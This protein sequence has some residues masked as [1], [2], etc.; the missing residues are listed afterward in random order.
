MGKWIP[1]SGTMYRTLV[2]QCI[3]EFDIRENSAIV[4]SLACYGDPA[5]IACNCVA[6]SSELLVKIRTP[7]FYQYRPKDQ[8][9]PHWLDRR[10]RQ[11]TGLLHVGQV[12]PT[13]SAH[14]DWINPVAIAQSFKIKAT[15]IEID[16][17]TAILSGLLANDGW[18]SLQLRHDGIYEL[19]PA[20]SSDQR[21]V[22]SA[23]LLQD[24]K[25]H[26]TIWE[27]NSVLGLG[28]LEYQTGYRDGDIS[29][30]ISKMSDAERF[31]GFTYVF[32][33]AG[34]SSFDFSVL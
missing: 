8:P 3:E 14:F 28:L 2:D 27:I 9:V 1:E 18:L 16:S 6:N 32:Q 12:V 33:L 19:V 11:T 25:A 29:I 24:C 22:R 4:E 23:T 30:E 5:G 20:L 13:S 17:A 10:F 31:E 15:A 34:E 7:Q 26:V 21:A